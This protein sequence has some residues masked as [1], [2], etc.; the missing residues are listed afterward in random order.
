MTLLAL[1]R[2]STKAQSDPPVTAT[3][4]TPATDNDDRRKCWQYA[5]LS[6]GGRCLAA[7]RGEH[8]GNGADKLGAARITHAAQCGLAVLGREGKRL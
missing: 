6:R 8:I 3:L 1:I 7:Y 4:A 5:N 2:G